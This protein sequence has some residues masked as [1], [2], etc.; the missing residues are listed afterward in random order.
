MPRLEIAFE[1]MCRLFTKVIGKPEA[2]GLRF[3]QDTIPVTVGAHDRE[4]VWLKVP[5][6]AIL[7]FALP[8]GSDVQDQQEPG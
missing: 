3:V 6:D 5:M 4:H 2:V 8:E 7:S 1:L